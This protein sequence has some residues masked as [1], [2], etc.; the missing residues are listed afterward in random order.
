MKHILGLMCPDEGTVTIEG[1]DVW[2]SS[3]SQLLEIRR[4]LSALHGGSTVYE[5]S[6]LGS[7]SLRDNLLTRLHEKYANPSTASGGSAT[8]INN[9]PY[10]RLWTEGLQQ[11][12]AIPELAEQAQYWL[13]RF[14][15]S[16]VAD[17]LPHEASAGQRRRAA[18]AAAL[19][20]DAQ[21]YLLDDPDGAIDRPRRRA[22]VDAILDTRGRT[23][24]TMLIATHDLALARAVSDQIAVLAGGRIV[25]HGAPEQALIDIERWYRV[26][27]S[28][29]YQRQ[30]AFIPAARR[31]GADKNLAGS[32]LAH[33]R[34]NHATLSPADAPP[35]DADSPDA[36]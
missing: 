22:I 23:N 9:N 33:S 12:Q 10:V 4:N 27:T 19:A 16:E 15:L 2:A 8:R 7:V 31:P 17:L 1:R 36:E 3:P 28:T 32:S 30:A 35:P 26:E 13:D 24:A 29:D 20:V 5:G 18:L 21:L 25:F 14:D 11:V 34:E 6:V